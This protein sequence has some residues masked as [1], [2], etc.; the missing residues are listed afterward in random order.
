MHKVDGSP[1]NKGFC[2]FAFTVTLRLNGLEHCPPS[3]VNV[4]VVV[5]GAEVFTTDGLQVPVMP[6]GEVVDS[7]GAVAPTHKGAIGA[8]L[9]SMLLLIVTDI[10]AGL[11]HCPALGVKV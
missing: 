11:A 3:G 5:P 4:Y 7:T 1:T 8:K 6:L 2:V 9:G 10:V